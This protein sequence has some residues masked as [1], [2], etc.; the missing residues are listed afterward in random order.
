M[1][2]NINKTRQKRHSYGRDLHVQWRP[3]GSTGS[4]VQEPHR[5]TIYVTDTVTYGNNLPDWRLRLLLGTSATTVL[6]GTRYS[7]RAS[8]LQQNAVGVG[9]QKGFGRVARGF[10]PQHYFPSPPLAT[11]DSVAERNAATSFLADYL[12]A[13][14]TWKGGAT[15]AEFGETVAMLASPVD[16][17]YKRTLTFVGSVGKLRKVYKRDPIRY[18]KLLG[19]LWLAYAFGIAPAVADVNSA[20]A[21]V[22]S[23]AEDLGSVDTKRIIGSGYNKVILN[24][25]LGETV[26]YANYCAADRTL[27]VEYGI[28][29]LGAVRCIPPS[30]AAIAEDFGVGFTDILPSVWEGIPWSWLVDYFV[31]VNEMLESIRLAFADFAW[32]NRTVRNRA[33]QSWSAVRPISAQPGLIDVTASG[34]QGYY[35]SKAVNR[36]TATVPYPSWRFR[37]PGLPSQFANVSALV[38]AVKGSK[39]KSNRP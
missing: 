21:A 28:R 27:M 15:I 35:E 37:I 19:Q 9:T 10:S 30:P 23:L 34:G 25:T 11:V 33:V 1:A 29:Y 2:R 13:T 17:L 20:Y 31:N 24:R 26:S 38:L 39:P 7:S 32:L 3:V 5:R 14:Q 6:S 22:K 8:E 16:S 4:F 12:K 36:V 18:G